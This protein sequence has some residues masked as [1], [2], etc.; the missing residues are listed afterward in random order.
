[1]NSASLPVFFIDDD[2]E[3]LILAHALFKKMPVWSPS[4][5][6]QADAVF[7]ENLKRLQ[8]VW[9]FSDLWMEPIDGLSLLKKIPSSIPV[10][11]LTGETNQT[12]LKE[13]LSLGAYATLPKKNLTQTLL[14]FYAQ[15]C[16]K[17]P[18]SG[19]TSA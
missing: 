19:S 2:P 12:L 6:H 4:F 7:F 5:F 3:I 9:L 17:T 11:F 10:V 8:P 18:V 14:D 16:P 13:L 1:M 15:H